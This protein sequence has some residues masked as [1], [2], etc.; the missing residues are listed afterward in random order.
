MCSGAPV[1]VYFCSDF[2]TPPTGAQT[3]TG[4]NTFPVGR[5]FRTFDAQPIPQ[6]SFGDSSASSGPLGDRVGA[7]FSWNTS[8]P[9]TLKSR[10]G[11]SFISADKACAFRDS[12][13]PSW[14]L[15]DTVQSAQDEW[16]R[17]VFSKIQTPTDT[18]ANQTLLTMLYSSLYFSHLIPSDRTDENPLWTSD[19]PYWDDFYTMWDLF[20]NTVGL[21]HLIQPSYYEGMI[22]A[23]IDIWR[24]VL[25]R[26]LVL[27]AQKLTRYRHEGFMPDGRS[28]N[29]NGLVQGG[30]NADNVN[31]SAAVT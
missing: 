3:F 18:S 29:Y 1:D 9:V 7:L 30:S 27:T 2:D 6:P 8:T 19:E 20:R 17:D 15:N 24:Y 10:V 13:I 23:V 12:E 22:R 28:G 25:D 14:N 16:N 5:Y 26:F 21:W 4:R 31:T 11:V